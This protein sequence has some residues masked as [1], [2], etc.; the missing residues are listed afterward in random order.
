MSPEPPLIRRWTTAQDRSKPELNEDASRADLRVGPTDWAALLVVADGAGS[1]PFAGAWAQALVDAAEPSWATDGIPQGVEGVRRGFNPMAQE[2]VDF[3]LE[4]L[5]NERGSA[6]TLSVAA[7]RSNGLR[8]RC[9]ASIVGDCLLLIS[10]PDSLS[11]F[12]LK[13]ASEFTSRTQAVSTQTGDVEVR[14]TSFDVPAG[15][16][17][18][19]SSDGIGAWLLRLLEAEGPGAVYE[20]LRAASDSA[21]PTVDDDVTLLVLYVPPLV[22][23]PAREGLWGRL[24]EAISRGLFPGGYQKSK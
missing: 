22:P 10:L 1:T 15:S 9:A 11:S 24:R 21:L 3:V 8:T 5:W 4:D 7:V 6:A 18:A 13:A 23:W 16:M 14:S 2:D 19:L 12:P 17:L 20:W